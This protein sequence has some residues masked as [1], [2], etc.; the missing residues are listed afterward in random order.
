MAVSPVTAT[1]R[2]TTYGSHSRSSEILVRTP[3]PV[4]GCHQCWTSPASELPRRRAQQVL[5]GEAS[6]GDREREDVLELVAEAVG[7]TRLVERRSC[8][9]PAGQRLVE[10]P[11]VEQDVHRPIRGPDLDRSQGGVPVRARPRRSV[12]AIVEVAP[13]P[14]QVARPPPGSSASPSRTRTVV[15]S[16]AASSKLHARAAH[17]SMPG[18]GRS[19]EPMAAL[20]RGRPVVG[21]VSPEELGPVGGPGFLPAAEVEEGDPVGEVGV[22]GVARQEGVR[23]RLEVG[24]DRRCGATRGRCPGPTRR[25]PSPTGGAG[26]RIGS[27][28]S[29]RRS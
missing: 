19:R 18:A 6:L 8:P 26:G 27:R 20:E 16:P 22:P 11:A 21:A 23:A 15:R 3:R 5:T 4:G 7:T 1:Y 24:H 17:G 2:L 13:A 29:G 12:A 14:D 25:R 9:Q 28:S 10:Q